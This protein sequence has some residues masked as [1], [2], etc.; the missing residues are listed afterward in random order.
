MY[1]FIIIFFVKGKL[2]DFH[3]IVVL[4]KKEEKVFQEVFSSY[5]WKFSLKFHST[6]TLKTLVDVFAM[7]QP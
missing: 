1:L 3:A 6:E 5:F 7:D 2:S 4:F